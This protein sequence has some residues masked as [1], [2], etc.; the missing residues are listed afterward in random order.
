[1]F[2]A[3]PIS[4][5]L[6]L[7]TPM[8]QQTALANASQEIRTNNQEQLEARSVANLKETRKGRQLRDQEEDEEPETGEKRR[9]PSSESPPFDDRGRKKQQQRA[10]TAQ[11]VSS[12]FLDITGTPPSADQRK[13][14]RVAYRSVS[15]LKSVDLIA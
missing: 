12:F 14:G 5:A 8:T 3:I 9:E 11:G 15:R 4:N 13:A 10:E 1:M 6:V 7:S 2:N